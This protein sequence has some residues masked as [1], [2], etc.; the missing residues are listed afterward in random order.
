MRSLR[1]MSLI[2]AVFSSY[3]I[4]ATFGQS[5]K[6]ND[7]N[8]QEIAPRILEQRLKSAPRN[9]EERAKTLRAM[10][11]AAGCGSTDLAEQLVHK[12]KPPNI[13]CKLP[14]ETSGLIIVGAHLD[15]VRRGDGIVDD[16]SGTSLLPSLYQ[17]LRPQSRRH[18]FLFIGFTEE[19]KGRRG[20][21]FY[22]KTLA[23][24]FVRR[25][26][27]MVNLECLGM[28]PPEVWADHAAR[29]CWP[30]WIVWRKPWGL[31][32]RVWIWSEWDMTMPSPSGIATC[33]QSRFIPSRRISSA[34]STARKTISR[35]ST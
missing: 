9:N 31:I 22:V 10:F 30:L 35:L 1:I 15:H 18:T 3:I 24:G 6:P 21:K 12:G 34:C 26:R 5:I 23:S 33:P 8:F 11:R 16:W 28:N 14:G 19:E 25:I 20:S 13:I 32:F 4:S 7:L 17:S 2:I 29:L 27:A